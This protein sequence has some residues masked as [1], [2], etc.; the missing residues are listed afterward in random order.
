MLTYFFNKA[1][2]LFWAWSKA[3]DRRL[4]VFVGFAMEMMKPQIFK[5]IFMILIL[6]LVPPMNMKQ[7]LTLLS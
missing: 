4:L 1:P 2:T 5:L 7:M 3:L 6:K